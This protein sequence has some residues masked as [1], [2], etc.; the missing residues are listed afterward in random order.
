[1]DGRSGEEKFDEEFAEAFSDGDFDA[2][3]ADEIEE[4]SF[5]STISRLNLGIDGLDRLFRGGVPVRSLIGVLGDSGTGKTTLGLQFL[6]HGLQRGERAIFITTEQTSTAV[7]ASG[8]EMGLEFSEYVEAGQLAVIDVHPS[9][10]TRAIPSIRKELPHLVAQFG[11]SRLVLD[12]V[13]LLEKM[14]DD[15]AT[16]E[17]EIYELVRALKRSGVTPLITS[18][19]AQE[20]SQRSKF[21]L[22]EGLTDTLLVLR[23]AST[24]GSDDLVLEIQKARSTAHSRETIPYE[25][26][27][28]GI[29]VVPRRQTRLHENRW[30]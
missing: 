29:R 30:R 19:T 11:A 12:S 17:S 18:R 1:M 16:R 26:T 15:D 14:Y 23:F 6:H 21:G 24:E 27:D 9:E 3:T 13:S 2:A 5:D 4:P 28:G 25:I 20:S 10:M 22:I 7:V 8:N